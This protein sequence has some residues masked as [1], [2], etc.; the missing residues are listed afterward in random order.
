[1]RKAVVGQIVV[2]TILALGGGTLIGLTSG[3]Y[4]WQKLTNNGK[5]DA[6]H[7]I[8]TFIPRMTKDGGIERLKIVVPCNKWF[9]KK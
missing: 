5:C 9:P 8:V 1:M 3:D 6:N 2:L 4:Q 7:D